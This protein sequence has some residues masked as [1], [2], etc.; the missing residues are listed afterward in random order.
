MK[1]IFTINYKNGE[2]NNTNPIEVQIPIGNYSHARLIAELNHWQFS[3]YLAGI[4]DDLSSP[5]W[6]CYNGDIKPDLLP[7]AG[8]M[9]DK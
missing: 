1:G 5:I 7:D 8:K 4:H 6:K 9:A 2:G 3:G